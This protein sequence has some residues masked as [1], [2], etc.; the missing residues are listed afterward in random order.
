MNI[1][2]NLR[3]PGSGA[4]EIQNLQVE[5]VATLPTFSALEKGRIVYNTTDEKLYI[6]DGTQFITIA[7]GGNT[8]VIQ[9][10]L[11]ALETA[12]GALVKS[13]GTFD[14]A[15]LASFTGLDTTGVT[16]VT[17]L[18]AA[19]NTRVE[20]L[21]STF[22]EL[23]D[24]S[25]TSL[26]N[27][28]VVQYNSTTSKWENK[29]LAAAGIQAKD[30]DLDAI[31]GLTTNGLVARTA[32]GVAATRTITGTT[33]IVVTNGDGVAGDPSLVLSDTTVTAGAY[34]GQITVD[35]K[36]RITAAQQLTSSDV[37]TALTYTPVNKAG[38][39]MSG[40][41]NMGSN[42]I[43]ALANP[44]NSTDAVNKNYVDSLVS[45]LSWKDPVDL[46]STDVTLESLTGKADGFRIVD[47]ATDKIFTVT[48][49]ALDAGVTPEDAWAVFDR[50]NE[51]GWVFSGN[52][53]VQFTGSGQIVAGVGLSKTG[54]R[55]D[56]EFGA[57][58]TAT[59]NEGDEAAKL[60]V[61]AGNGLYLDT[62]NASAKV[63]VKADAEA[64][65][66]VTVDGVK[67]AATGV[68][69]SHLGADVIGNGLQGAN[70]TAIAVKAEDTT[71]TVGAAGIKANIGTTAGT[72]AAGDHTHAFDDLTDVTLTSATNKQ[73]LVFNGT[74][75]VNKTTYFAFVAASANT[76]HTVTHNIGTKYVNVSVYDDATGE[77]IIPQSIV[78]TDDN[79]VTVTVTPAVKVAVVVTGIA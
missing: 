2:G 33:D 39:T 16:T 28:D 5:R 12:L 7:T 50:S 40:A 60:V 64:S 13:D 59:P 17:G 55:L 8:Q 43:T 14:T 32:D 23:T 68:K 49:E 45:G 67:V 18:V 37:T 54:N 48:S 30:A 75:W 34:N 26:A 63:E 31:A 74:A 9:N 44:V 10:E 46:V 41:L 65:I 79:N 25:L 15:Q 78:L 57:G 69:A 51:S 21:T 53:W 29:T 24:V 20:N 66:A 52:Q 36:G 19:I 56:V 22:A 11:D 38:D 73:T 71:I 42:A 1:L 35:A 58:I 62:A 76:S 27:A 6:N 77:A 72:V 47:L 3:L 70:G 4:G 61:D